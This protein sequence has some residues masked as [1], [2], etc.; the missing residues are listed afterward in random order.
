MAWTGGSDGAS[1][2][3]FHFRLRISFAIGLVT[4]F[5]AVHDRRG[6]ASIDRKIPVSGNIPIDGAS[7]RR[8]SIAIGQSAARR[9]SV[10]LRGSYAMQ[11]AEKKT[12]L[13]AS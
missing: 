11:A 8:G 7:R 1:R 2:R 10:G 6:C 12:R 4:V 5:V 3:M 9:S 13:Y